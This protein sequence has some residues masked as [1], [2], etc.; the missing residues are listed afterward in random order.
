MDSLAGVAQIPDVMSSP[1]AD[2]YA[3]CRHD[4]LRAERDLATRVVDSSRSGDLDPDN[5]G[6]LVLRLVESVISIRA[7]GRTI[8]TPIAGA[9]ASSCLRLCCVSAGAGLAAQSI[10][11]HRLDAFATTRRGWQRIVQV[12]PRSA[13][14][15]RRTIDCETASHPTRCGLTERMAN[16]QT[17]A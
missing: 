16:D 6:E 11:Q 3:A 4:L 5:L 17:I 9:I 14:R 2:E 1:A 8:T 10:A 7:N 13:I 12:R 15:I